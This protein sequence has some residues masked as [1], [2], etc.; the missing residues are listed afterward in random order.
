MRPSK[1][2]GVDEHALPVIEQ[3]SVNFDAA[4]ILR[5]VEIAS[6]VAEALGLRPGDASTVEFQPEERLV[7]FNRPERPD[8]GRSITAEALVA[9]LVAYCARIGVPL[10]RKG[11]KQLDIGPAGVTLRIV[12][13]Q[14]SRDS[15]ATLQQEYP[16]AMVWPRRRNLRG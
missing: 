12:V 11:Q 14:A 2:H 4:E 13:E 6:R 10:P 7:R 3:R 5:A 16:G 9:V 8:L 15:T 1:C